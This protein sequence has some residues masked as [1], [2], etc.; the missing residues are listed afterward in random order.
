MSDGDY[1]DVKTRSGEDLLTWFREVTEETGGTPA[2]LRTL[3]LR[4][5]ELAM[6]LV[7]VYGFGEAANLMGV[8]QLTLAALAMES[9]Q[10]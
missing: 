9:G 1:G 6:A 7:Q 3:A 10:S 8:S 2:R 4:R 5:R